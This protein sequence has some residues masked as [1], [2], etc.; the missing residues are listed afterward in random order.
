MDALI[1]SLPAP[2]PLA[3]LP[4]ELKTRWQEERQTLTQKLDEAGSSIAASRALPPRPQRRASSYPAAFGAIAAVLLIG[5]VVGFAA[6]L[7]HRQSALSA[8]TSFNGDFGPTVLPTG[9]QPWVGNWRQISLPNGIPAQ[10]SN[11]FAVTPQTSAPELLYGCYQAGNNPLAPEPRR[12]WRSEDGGHT[13]T[14]LNA[15][16]GSSP[17]QEGCYVALSPGAPDAIFLNGNAGGLSYYSLDRG[18]HWQVLQQPAGAELWDVAAPTAEGDVWYYI[19][20]VGVTQ[21]EIW[22]SHDHGAQW[23][24]HMYPVRV[25]PSLG[26]DG[27]Y[28]GVV[29]LLLRYEKGGLLFLFEHTLW[30]SPDYGAT[31][32]RLETWSEPPCDRSIVG[33]PDLSVLYC[34]AWNGAQ[35]PQPYWR[36]LNHGQT[37]QPVPAEPSTQ[38][39]GASLASR[40]FPP[41][42]LRDGALLELSVIPED[43]QNAALFSLAPG[44][45]VWRQASDPLNGVIG[46]CLGVRAGST[47]VPP[48]LGAAL[49]SYCALDIGAPANGLNGAQ[50][51]YGLPGATG[52]ILVAEI[53]WK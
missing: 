37:W 49:F 47:T 32:R 20:T 27:T 10:S 12:L 26:D 44:S 38:S 3:S 5:V 29:P 1:R 18:D 45:N 22:V 30:W 9:P 25:P 4:T 34:V 19:R 7:D 17:Q 46:G 13:W 43:P 51:L 42:V 16:A 33:T 6:L 41:A 23:V 8:T 28:P 14:T 39:T 53:T 31:W 40:P 2:A 11:H 50:Y 24:K 21:P 48:P 35:K 15:P 52:K 36:S